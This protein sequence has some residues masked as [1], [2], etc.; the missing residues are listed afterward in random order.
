M[1]WTMQE[2]AI[3]AEGWR[4]ASHLA[5]KELPRPEPPAEGWQ[6]EAEDARRKD[7]RKLRAFVARHP[8]I[9]T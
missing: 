2:H 6:Q 4:I 3:H 8:E 1:A 5:G 7:E 9:N